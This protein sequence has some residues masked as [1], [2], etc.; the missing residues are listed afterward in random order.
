MASRARL[1]VVG[2][3]IGNLGDLS[4]RA[5]EAL[6]GAD[7][8]FVEDSRVSGTLGPV[9][10][11]KKPMRVLNDHT[12]TSAIERFL[13]EVPADG[14]AC[15]LSDGGMPVVSDPGTLLIDA[16]LERGW[17]VDCIPGPS[18]VTTALALSGF[19]GQR[20]AF[21]GFLPRKPG[22]MRGELAPFADSPLTLVI[23]ENQFRI[24][25]LFREAHQV[26]GN[27]RVAVTRELT[28]LHQQVWRG[29]LETVP[30][31]TEVPRKGEFTIVIEGTRKSRTD[32]SERG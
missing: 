31:E 15:V 24:G 27:R 16:A 28:K 5:R 9:L 21:L 22:P 12:A 8:W 10:G 32:D 13:D 23:F 14:Y 29:T 7:L 4:P 26:L 30:D 1:V 20:F 17:T 2:T 19:F 11:V 25:N 3:P 6:S 18:A